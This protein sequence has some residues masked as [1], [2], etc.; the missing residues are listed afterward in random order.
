MKNPR[1]GKDDSKFYA[2]VLTMAAHVDVE[3]GRDGLV[4]GALERLTRAIVDEERLRGRCRDL[5]VRAATRLRAD[6]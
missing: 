4:S 5:D 3:N 2:M 1:S 6:W